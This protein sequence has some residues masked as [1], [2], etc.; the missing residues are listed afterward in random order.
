MPYPSEANGN[1]AREQE[2]L[3]EQIYNSWFN[4]YA[5]GYPEHF[6]DSYLYSFHSEMSQKDKEA[7]TLQSKQYI[8]ELFRKD[9]IERAPIGLGMDVNLL[10]LNGTLDFI[11]KFLS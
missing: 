1:K 5:L 7:Y 10:S 9:K 3:R 8:K 4:G 6:I 2:I 11:A